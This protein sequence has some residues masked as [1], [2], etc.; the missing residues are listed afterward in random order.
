MTRK[1]ALRVIESGVP[2]TTP[3][4]NSYARRIVHLAI[5]EFSNLQ[6]ESVGDGPHKKIRV[7]PAG[8]QD[9]GIEQRDRDLDPEA[10]TGSQ[11]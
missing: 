6:S 4:L 10:P 1:M 5:T 11:D 2:E 7:A 8:D 3:P 9:R